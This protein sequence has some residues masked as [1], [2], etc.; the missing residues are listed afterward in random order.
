M[1]GSA[2]GVIMPCPKVPLKKLMQSKRK[3]LRLE[4]LLGNLAA[5]LG[6]RKEAREYMFKAVS[7]RN[8]HALI[9]DIAKDALRLLKDSEAMES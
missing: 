1:F 8:G 7:R 3:F 2:P 9:K 6:N 4:Y 5:T